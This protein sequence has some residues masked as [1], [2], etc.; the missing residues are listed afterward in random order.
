[1]TKINNFSIALQTVSTP[2]W[3]IG[4]TIA[5]T[6]YRCKISSGFG[7]SDLAS[8]TK[9]S[10]QIRVLPVGVK[11]SGRILFSHAFLRDKS[12]GIL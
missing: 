3:S 6:K 7:S 8:Q 5:V 11:F 10:E 2:R 1:M 4:N 12:S 9:C